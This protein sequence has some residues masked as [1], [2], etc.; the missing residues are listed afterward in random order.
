MPWAHNMAESMAVGTIPILQY[1]NW[2][3]PPLTHNENC[4]AF[5]DAEDLQNVI[6]LALEMAQEEIERMRKNVILYYEKHLSPASV[7]KKLDKFM[8]SD[9]LKMMVAVPFI[10]SN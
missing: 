5:K 3:S 10:P 4:L 6:E 2:C 7:V 9:K 8:H 1:T